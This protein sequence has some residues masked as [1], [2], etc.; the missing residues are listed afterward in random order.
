MK[1]YLSSLSLIVGALTTVAAQLL[2]FQGALIGNDGNPLPDGPKLVQFQI[3]S[4]PVEGTR[5]WEGEVHRLSLT[6]GLANTVLGTKAPFPERYTENKNVLLMFSQPLYLEL[7]VDSNGNGSIDD[8]DQA[9]LPRQV[10]LPAN[11]ARQAQRAVASDSLAGHG[12]SALMT[13]D[14]PTQSYVRPNR[15]EPESISQEHLR[16]DSRVPVGTVIQSLLAPELFAQAVGDPGSF[17]PS[18][19]KWVLAD[20]EREIGSSEYGRLTSASRSPDLR[21]VFLRGINMGREGEFRD[22]DGNRNPGHIQKFALQNHIHQIPIGYFEN[23][24]GAGWSMGHLDNAFGLHRGESYG[25]GDAETR[26]T[27]AAVYHYLKIN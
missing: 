11:F 18:V 12:W 14:D 9:L 4:L 10:I 6:R 8:G 7:V 26:P 27:N 1:I 19:S 24:E 23:S 25:F 2:P 13:G 16:R 15:I 3:F 21:G 5:V 17:D 20:G 22:P